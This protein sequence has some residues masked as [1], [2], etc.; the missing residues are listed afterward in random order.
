MRKTTLP[1]F[2]S[3]FV[4]CYIFW[5]LITGQIPAVFKGGAAPQILIIGVLVSVLAAAFTARFF[6]HSSAFH[7]F[8]PS[9]LG[10]FICYGFGVFIKELVKANIDVAKRAF[11]PALPVNPGI[12]KIPTELK[13][14]YGLSM[15][16]NSIT[17]TPGT[18]TLDVAEEDG[19]NNLYVHWIDVGSEDP[20]EAGDQIKGT[21]ESWIRRIFK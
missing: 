1:A 15:L 10:T 16:S 18:I 20:V 12:V 5:L 4:V 9:R 17:L 3:T 14:D 8:S 11:S 7:L 2:I 13:S 6:I 21:M 19:Q